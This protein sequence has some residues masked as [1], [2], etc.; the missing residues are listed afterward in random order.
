[1]DHNTTELLTLGEAAKA[2]RISKTKLYL[3]R[4]DGKIRAVQIGR[5]TRI[6]PAD[7][8]QYVNS[9]RRESTSEPQQ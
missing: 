2:L 4:R 9:L 3:E 7:L 5:A 6:A 8:S 1:M